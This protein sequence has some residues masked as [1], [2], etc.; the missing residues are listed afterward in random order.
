MVEKILPAWRIN[1][2]VLDLLPPGSK[3][4][5]KG[6]EDTYIEKRPNHHFN[7][8]LRRENRT[9]LFFDLSLSQLLDLI[10]SF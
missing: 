8:Y 2:Q 1:R 10:K 4:K 3:I 5:L 6:Y 9:R 7:L